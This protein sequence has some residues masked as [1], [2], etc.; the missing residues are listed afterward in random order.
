MSAKSTKKSTFKEELFHKIDEYID[1]AFVT[2]D[3]VKRQQYRE[4]I[5]C[6]EKL[7]VAISDLE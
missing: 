3:T 5:R 7:L 4:A 2:D 6:I 1:Q